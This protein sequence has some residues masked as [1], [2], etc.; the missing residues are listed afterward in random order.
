MCKLLE[1]IALPA[2]YTA[3]VAESNLIF[4]QQ[5]EN[6]CNQYLAKQAEMSCSRVLQAVLQVGV[7]PVDVYSMLTCPLSYCGKAKDA[8]PH[9]VSHGKFRLDLLCR[10]YAE[11]L[12]A[13]CMLLSVLALR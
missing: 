6:N 4:M 7:R 8:T 2:H 1:L 3:A 9:W 13:L 5:Q 12:L 11:M 10:A